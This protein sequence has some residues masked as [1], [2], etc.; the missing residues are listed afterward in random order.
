MLAIRALANIFAHSPGRMYAINE[1]DAIRSLVGPQ[2][3]PAATPVNRNVHIAATTLYI[4]YAVAFAQVSGVEA[5]GRIRPLVEDLVAMLGNKQVV[6]SE[7]LYRGL[8]GVGSLLSVAV[9]GG[10]DDADAI[11]KLDVR[12]AL[13]KA[14]EKAREPRVKAVV[15]EIKEMLI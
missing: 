2:L 7:A 1:F 5:G 11:N 4:N 10:G 8:V 6:D 12:V 3:R 9:A 14:G 15:D 13:Q